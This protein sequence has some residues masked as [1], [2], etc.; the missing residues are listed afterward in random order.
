M[1]ADIGNPDAFDTA[2]AG[3][4]TSYRQSST[5]DYDP[6]VFVMAVASRTPKTVIAQVHGGLGMRR[7]E[8]TATKRGAPPILPAAVD[9]DTDTLIGCNINVPLPIVDPTAATYDWAAH[10]VYL[11]VTTGE[12]GPR[13]PGRDPLP[14]GQYP[15]PTPTQDAAIE[16]LA[17]GPRDMQTLMDELPGQIPTNDYVWPFTVYPPAFFNSILLR[18]FD[19]NADDFGGGDF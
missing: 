18:D 16:A 15:F 14:L 6:G 4:Y 7:V 1:P 19:G 5:F 8:V 17:T 13:V 10:G 2:T 9:T 11:F 12:D 3:D